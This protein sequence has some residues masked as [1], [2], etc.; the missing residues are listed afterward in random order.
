MKARGKRDGRPWCIINLTTA[1]KGRNTD[2][3]F[4]PSGLVL[5]FHINQGRRAPLC[6]A[7]AP[8][9]HISRLWRWIALRRDF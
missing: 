1:L 6:V 4:G 9:C 5:S 7:L 2:A 8:G 3:Y